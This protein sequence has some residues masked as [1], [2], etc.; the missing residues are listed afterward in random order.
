MANTCVRYIGELIQTTKITS[1]SSKA[2]T[3]RK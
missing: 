2:K 1:S 3:G